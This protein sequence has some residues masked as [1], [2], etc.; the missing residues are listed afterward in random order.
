MQHSTDVINKGKYLYINPLS[1]FLKSFFFTFV[2]WFIVSCSS[3]N[4]RYIRKVNHLI[5]LDMAVYYMHTC[6]RAKKE[7]ILNN[8][9]RFK[10]FFE[11]GRNLIE[12][13]DMLMA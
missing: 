5:D 6:S 8:F 10:N 11:S 7:Y 4:I 9:H 2:P 13:M 3:Q 12:L 1:H